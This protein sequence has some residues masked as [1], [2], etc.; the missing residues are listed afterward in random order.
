MSLV[1]F[2]IQ[3]FVFLLLSFMCSLYIWKIILC[4]GY[5]FCKLFSPSHLWLVFSLTSSVFHRIEKFKFNKVQLITS[6]I[7]GFDFIFKE[8]L[9]EYGCVRL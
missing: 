8:C 2:L 1:H 4:I 6:F 5:I 9:A 7:P 3:L